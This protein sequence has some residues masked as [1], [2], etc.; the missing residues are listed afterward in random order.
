MAKKWIQKA[1][2]NPGALHRSLGIPMAHKIPMAKL[3]K[4]AHSKNPR[5]AGRAKLAITLR[6]LG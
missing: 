2:K 6:H 5:L 4:A 3:E 1:I